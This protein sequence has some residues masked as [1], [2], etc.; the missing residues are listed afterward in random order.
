M[1]NWSPLTIG[2]PTAAA[3]VLVSAGIVTYRKLHREK[4]P[5]EL[6]RLRRLA[7]GRTGRIVAGEITGLIEPEGRE[8]PP[9]QLVYRYDIAGVTFEVTQDVSMLPQV[10]ASAA[11][12]LGKTISVKYEMR[13]PSN[14]IVVCEVWSGIRGIDLREPEAAG[15]PVTPNPQAVGEGEPESGG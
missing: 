6:E 10:A 4:D 7:L 13:Q 5:A 2:L 14:S 15:S 8:A 3:A 9:L 11:H 1:I 12:L